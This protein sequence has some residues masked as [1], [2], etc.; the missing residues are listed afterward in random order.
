MSFQQGLSGLNAAAKALDVTSN[1]VANTST[2]GYK[3]STAQFQDVYA[4]SLGGAGASQIGIGTQ[5]AQVAQQFTQG[6]I[7][8]TSNPLDIAINGA[9]FFRM[10]DNG[11]ISYSR[12]GQFNVDKDGHIVNA[13]GLRLTGFP[14]DPNG[15]VVPATPADL[16]INSSD[17]QPAA[18]TSVETGVNLDSRVASPS[19]V[20]FNPNNPLTYNSSTSVTVF[21]SLGNPH[22]MTMYF[23]KDPAPAVRQWTVHANMDGGAITS[24]TLN[25]NT[26]GALTTA[27]P[28]A[29]I[30]FPVTSGASNIVATLD[31][32]GTTA[33]G[34]T[35]GVNRMSQNGYTSGQLSGV[36]IG[37]DGLVQGRYSNGRSRNMGQVVLANF[38]NAGGLTSVG[39]NQ[40]TE[41]AESGTPLIGA[42]GSASLGAIQSGAVE[43]SNVDLTAELVNMITQQRTYQANAQSIRTQ[44]QILQTLVNLR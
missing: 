21:D 15:I 25:F 1:N 11:T 23:V 16:L 41:S 22:V 17:L 18:T 19:V 3:A 14:A 36:A 42:P 8:I 27:M 9:G 24:N 6:N 38:N 12:N 37:T 31:F 4:A 28:L 33:F 30:T 10:S 13:A 34:S 20:P 2:V 40:W 35:F 26:N 39:S 29:A 44:D 43:D 7:T 5:V 32:S